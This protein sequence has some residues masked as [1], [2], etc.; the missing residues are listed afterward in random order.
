MEGQQK[1]EACRHNA[2][3]TRATPEA[4]E[5]PEGVD[6]KKGAEPECRH[7]SG[8]CKTALQARDSNASMHRALLTRKQAARHMYVALDALLNQVF[9]WE[10]ALWVI[11]SHNAHNIGRMITRNCNN[12]LSQESTLLADLMKTPP[13]AEDP[14]N[15]N[16]TRIVGFMFGWLRKSA[17]Y[18]PQFHIH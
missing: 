14:N 4:H 18:A 2:D 6:R 7:T 8:G 13:V 12:A 16:A 15:H 1:R 11:T 10:S 9:S 17:S 3:G 5:Q